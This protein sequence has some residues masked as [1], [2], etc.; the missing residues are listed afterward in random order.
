MTAPEICAYYQ[1]RAKAYGV[2]DYLHVN[3]RVVGAV[4]DVKAGV[5]QVRVE[6]VAQS[7]TFTDQAE[8]VINATGFLK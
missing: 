6:D 8:F 7:R 4:W 1:G 2:Y 5:W 3:H